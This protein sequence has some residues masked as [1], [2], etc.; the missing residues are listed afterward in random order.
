MA[1]NKNYKMGKTAAVRRWTELSIECYKRGCVCTGCFYRNF[2]AK[3]NQKCH[4]K[5]AVL[6]LVRVLGM[7]KDVEIKIIIE[8]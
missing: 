7:P 6:E 4:M 1:I 2:F 8:D 3:S 5:A